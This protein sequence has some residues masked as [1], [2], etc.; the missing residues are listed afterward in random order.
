MN[1]IRTW[2]AFQD[3]SPYYRSVKTDGEESVWQEIAE[4]YDA[5]VYPDDHL[6]KLIDR[7]MPHIKGLETL[8]DVG[9]GPGTLALPLS[10]HL[11]HITAVEPSPAMSET[12][13]RRLK[14]DGIANVS[15]VRDRWEA[16]MLPAADA[17]IAGG[18]LYVFYHIDKVLQKMCDAAKRKVI[19]TSVGDGG[20]WDF[21]CRL[22]ENLQVPAPC[23][24]PSVPMTLDV[25]DYL[26]LTFT[27]ETFYVEIRKILSSA[28]WQR[29]CGEYLGIAGVDYACVRDAVGID[30][31][32]VIICE[33]RPVT[34]IVIQL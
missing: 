1:P 22:L 28:T 33:K 5:V 29:R 19:L 17:V 18:C 31:D 3:R 2:Q 6:P 21:E 15:V 13:W 20:L 12:L 10:G 11:R 27:T 9:S 4:G 24:F 16:V 7:L 30:H 32:P 25:L 14:R 8:I 26:G 34:L 23:L